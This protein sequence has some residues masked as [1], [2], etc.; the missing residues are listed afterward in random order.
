[1][2][3]AERRRAQWDL[4]VLELGSRGVHTG[5]ARGLSRVAG[6]KHLDKL[7]RAWVSRRRVGL[8]EPRRLQRLCLLHIYTVQLEYA[9][10]DSSWADHSLHSNDKF[11]LDERELI[12]SER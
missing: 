8:G 5:I 11:G 1:M 9:Q 12:V 2:T 4:Y 3:I 7:G 10:W 6:S